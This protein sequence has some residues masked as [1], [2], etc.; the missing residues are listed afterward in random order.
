VHFL[1]EAGE[2]VGGVIFLHDEGVLRSQSYWRG[3]G[4]ETGTWNFNHIAVPR[5]ERETFTDSFKQLLE[6]YIEIS[7][8]ALTTMQGS[9]VTCVWK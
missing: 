1:R 4:E 5:R 7:G 8:G 2:I 9:L 3:V 6:G